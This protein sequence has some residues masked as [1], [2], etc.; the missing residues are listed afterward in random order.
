MSWSHHLLYS[1]ISDFMV[2]Y[3]S[4][5][6]FNSSSLLHRATWNFM[7]YRALMLCLPYIVFWGPFLFV[8]DLA[9]YTFLP[10]Y[11]IVNRIT[12]SFTRFIAV[13]TPIRE[14]CPCFCHNPSRETVQSVGLS[15]PGNEVLSF[16]FS[17]ISFFNFC[18]SLRHTIISSHQICF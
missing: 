15:S 18:S 4:W 9:H 7:I 5:K 13:A 8:P 14:S 11:M 2:V 3:W 16:C 10:H 6:Y 17:L 1:Y 12:L